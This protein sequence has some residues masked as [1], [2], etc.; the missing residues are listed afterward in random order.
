MQ[1]TCGVPK[2]NLPDS[3]YQKRDDYPRGKQARGCC[4]EKRFG[5]RAGMVFAEGERARVRTEQ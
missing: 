2:I 3:L 4:S 1:G 5:T